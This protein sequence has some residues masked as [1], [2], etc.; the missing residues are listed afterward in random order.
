[1][2]EI[3]VLDT[4]KTEVDVEVEE[5]LLDVELEDED[6]EEVE[7]TDEDEDEEEEEEEEGR[8]LVTF[9][10]VCCKESFLKLVIEFRTCLD[11]SGCKIRDS[12][13]MV[14]GLC[15]EDSK[16]EAANESRKPKEPFKEQ[17]SRNRKER[18]TNEISR[19][20]SKEN[21][22]NR[23]NNQTIVKRKTYKEISSRER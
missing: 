19:P 20:D 5:G 1:M 23:H 3:S 14:W 22:F 2:P 12:D 11:S 15:M 4:D 10:V 21:R 13:C 8:E 9:V 17:L 6:E 7:E 16:K 18:G